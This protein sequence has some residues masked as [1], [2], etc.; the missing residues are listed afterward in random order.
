MSVL[1]DLDGALG[2]LNAQLPGTVDGI[3]EQ[4]LLNAH[5]FIGRR[6]YFCGTVV[7]RGAGLVGNP[8]RHAHFHAEI[9]A[10]GHKIQSVLL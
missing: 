4:H 10:P 7:F 2:C 6:K 8:S 1:A 9:R 5:P 3:A